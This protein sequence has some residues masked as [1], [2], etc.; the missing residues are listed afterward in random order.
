[1]NI[2]P[3]FSANYIEA[4]SK[5]LEAC[6]ERALP[7]ESHLNPNAK[8]VSGE[9][10]FTD[11][12]RIGPEKASKVLLIVSGTHGVEGYCGSGAQIGLLTTDVF[13]PLPDDLSVIM[14]HGLNPYG[15]SHDRRVNE[16]NIDLNRNFI[17]FESDY[18]PTSRYAEIH[19][20]LVPKDW[21]GP[22]YAAA[23]M[24]LAAFAER[25]GMA[26]YQAAVSSGQYDY[27]DGIFFGGKKPA[28]SNTILRNIVSEYL[29][30]AKSVAV[31]DFHTGL[32][33]YGYGEIISVGTP[34][35]KAL[36]RQFY[37]DQVTDPHAGTS[38]SAPLVGE[39]A[40]GIHE[41]LKNAQMTFVALEFGTYDLETVLTAL[42][43][44]NWL[45][46]EDNMNSPQA[47][48]IK[49]AIRKAFYPDTPD[50]KEAVWSRSQKVIDLALK[51]LDKID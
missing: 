27:P 1:L 5:F 22:E 7:V 28:W 47:Q 3:F 19:Q 21:E 35:Q 49:I 23:N 45:Y 16:D 43:G 34:K 25:Y 20:D 24:R 33:P 41:S 17:D 42:R 26:V 14:I 15:F 40:N 51:G 37:G 46:K 38:T 11:V 10:L 8:G 31:I 12:V 32:G 44:D 29:S 9:E 18:H 6:E 30:E 2:E 13:E 36:S 39:I 50:W 48:A 4:R